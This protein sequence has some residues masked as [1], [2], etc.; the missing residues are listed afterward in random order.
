MNRTLWVI[1]VLSWACSPMGQSTSKRATV[2]E[3]AG[4]ESRDSLA[5]GTARERAGTVG[6]YL[7]SRGTVLVREVGGLSQ[8]AVGAERHTL[9]GADSASTAYYV[10]LESGDFKESVPE[11][12]VAP[13]LT[14]LDS[15]IQLSRRPA[16]HGVTRRAKYHTA[17]GLDF[18]FLGGLAYLE[19][20]SGDREV[21]STEDWPK[22]RDAIAAARDSLQALKG[23]GAEFW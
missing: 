15:L 10:S 13:L 16:R 22:L 6:A 19:G 14:G 9:L 7:E 12:E 20:R 21:L 2:S 11:V 1:A 17:S 4:K 8:I 18:G 5:P 3:A 23:R